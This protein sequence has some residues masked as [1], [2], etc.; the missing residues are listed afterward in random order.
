MNDKKGEERLRV[1]QTIGVS[2]TRILEGLKEDQCSGT[3]GTRV[4][5]VQSEDGYKRPN[6]KHPPGNPWKDKISLEHDFFNVF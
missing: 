5:R 1:F 4:R 6:D 2:D 3:K